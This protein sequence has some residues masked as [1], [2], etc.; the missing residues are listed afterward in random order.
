MVYPSF[1]SIWR[2]TEILNP[3]IVT[4][5]SSLS[6]SD[7]KFC[8]AL[9]GKLWKTADFGFSTETAS[10]TTLPTEHSRGTPSYRAPELIAYVST[11]S[12]KVDIWGPG[13]I[14]YELVAK[15]KAFADDWAVQEYAA[16]KRNIRVPLEYFA[17]EIHRPLTNFIHK[18]LQVNP[19]ARRGAQEL[20]EAFSN[21]VNATLILCETALTSKL[22]PYLSE[23]VESNSSQNAMYV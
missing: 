6:P 18:M 1:T 4:R 21:L 17:S 2:C 13:C 3:Q 9:N 8:I 12:N 7:G 5:L 10:R 22:F 19:R 20:H 14:L 16:R 11:F 23:E 15:R